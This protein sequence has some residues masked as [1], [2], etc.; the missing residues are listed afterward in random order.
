M[1]DL[2]FGQHAGWFSAP[3]LIGTFFFLLRLLL[4]GGDHGDASDAVSFDVGGHSDG[5]AHHDSHGALKFLSIQAICAFLMGFGWTGFAAYRGSG[6]GPGVSAVVGMGGGVGMVWVLGALLRGAMRLE[7][8]GN[9]A[10]QS[11]V[12][13]EGEIYVTVPPAGKGRGQVRLVMGDRH[14]TF[15]AVSAGGE[16]RPSTRVK[17]VRVNDDR[18]LTVAPAATPGGDPT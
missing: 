11:A 3:A 8:S 9:I 14:R 13:R 15:N 6:L 18:T 10:I 7:G 2:L 17:V 16:I 4:P 1:L 12:G 5:M